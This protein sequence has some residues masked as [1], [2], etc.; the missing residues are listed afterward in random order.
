MLRWFPR[1]QVATAC[2]SCSPPDLS[3]LDPYFIFMHMRYN[4]CHRVTAQLQLNNNNNNNN[5][6]N[7]SSSNNNNN[8]NNNNLLGFI[9]AVA[10]FWKPNDDV[11]IIIIIII[12]ICMACFAKST[13]NRCC[14]ILW[15]Y[16]LLYFCFLYSYSLLT[17]PGNFILI[18]MSTAIEPQSQ[19]HKKAHLL[20]YSSRS[21]HSRNFVSYR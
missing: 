1:L 8:N 13:S 15:N 11:I 12:I 7:N 3:F 9:T 14:N 20:Q 5:I 18:K 17:Y 4:Q 19:T 6:N 21:T 10:I 2:F 16:L